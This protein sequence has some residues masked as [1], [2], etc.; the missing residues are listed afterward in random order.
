MK[1]SAIVIIILLSVACTPEQPVKPILQGEKTAEITE[2][3]N[4]ENKDGE[5]TIGKLRYKEHNEYHGDQLFGTIYY[6]R[7]GSI[8]GKSILRYENGKLPSGADFIDPQDSVMSFYKYIH[9]EKDRKKQVIAFDPV[10]KEIL[11]EERFFYDSKD[12]LKSKLIMD[13]AGVVRQRFNWTYDYYGNERAMMADHGDNTP[14]TTHEHRITKYDA[15]S[16]W[17]EKWTFIN[18]EPS[19]Y[20]KIKRR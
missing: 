17:V 5:H 2:I 1:D 18:D 16:L 14:L 15:D 19:A 7:D 10:N 13:D 3:F 20:Y 6:N 12:R 9:D 11:R 4:V 8:R